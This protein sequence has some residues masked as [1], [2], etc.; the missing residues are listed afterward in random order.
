M[1]QITGAALPAVD[2][3]PCLQHRSR[4]DV[5]FG[6]LNP[7]RAHTQT[8]TLCLSLSR[9]TAWSSKQDLTHGLSGA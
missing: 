1:Q 7:S 5:Y 8:Q 9:Y 3:P 4:A 6:G 2:K